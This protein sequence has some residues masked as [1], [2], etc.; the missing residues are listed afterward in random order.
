MAHTECPHL[1]DSAHKSTVIYGIGCSS[2]RINGI[3]V[4]ACECSLHKL[5][6]PHHKATSVQDESIVICHNCLD[7][8]ANIASREREQKALDN[9]KLLAAIEQDK[10]RLTS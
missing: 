8:P 2:Q 5:C 1:G 6:V 10:M 4:G 7:N 3:F 9:E